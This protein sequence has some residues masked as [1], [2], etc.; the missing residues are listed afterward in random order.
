MRWLCFLVCFPSLVWA[1]TSVLFVNPSLQSDPFFMQV[2]ALARIAATQ[3][4]I[5]LTVIHGDANRLFQ[6]Q[7]IAEYLEKNHPHYIVVQPYSGGG[8]QLM[9]QLADYPVKII[10]LERLWQ[11]DEE[12]VVGR[13]GGK[14]PN[15]LAE[16]YFD[17]TEASRALT[18]ALQQACPDANRLI[19]I[20]GAYS[21]ETDRRA[22][23]VYQ[24]MRQ[25]GGVVEQIVN[26]KWERPIAAAQVE[27]LLRRYPQTQLI[28]T[29]S[30]WMALGVIDS[31]E[32]FPDQRFCVGGFDWLPQSQYALQKGTLTASAGG[33]FA[34][35]AWAMVLIYDD[36]RGKLPKPMPD[37]P[38]L[39]LEILTAKNLPLYQPLLRAGQWQFVDFK[40]FSQSSRRTPRA[41]YPFTLQEALRHYQ[42]RN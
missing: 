18:I 23:G 30:D 17:N 38:L 5:D 12:P 40:A 29:A 31:L 20:N 14:Y 36:V 26:G 3:L 11:P 7:K 39:Q 34:M 2:E 27:Q 28:W 42:P 9:E 15:W 33:H 24:A 22:E 1:K 4:D 10:T 37:I 19:G 35:A 16:L 41:N 8:V 6:K 32:K 25:R 13:P 21:Q